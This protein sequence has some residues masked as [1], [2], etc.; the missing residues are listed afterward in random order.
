MLVVGADGKVAKKSVEVSG[1]Q[2]GKWVVTKGVAIG[3]KV[4]V[5]GSTKATP[6]KPVKA[7]A[8]SDDAAVIDKAQ[9]RGGAGGQTGSGGASGGSR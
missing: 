7:V 3:D 1:I 8:A 5:Q 4:I 9:G 2:G 6:G